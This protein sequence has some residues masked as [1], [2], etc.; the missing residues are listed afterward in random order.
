M[1][2]A[3]AGRLRSSPLAVPKERPDA[4]DF[5][6]VAS[7]F[8]ELKTAIGLSMD[9][10]DGASRVCHLG[11]PFMALMSARCLR[12][13]KEITNFESDFWFDE[14]PG[15]PQSG[16]DAFGTRP[17]RG[18]AGT[19]MAGLARPANPYLL[20][21]ACWQRPFRSSIFACFRSVCEG[22]R[23]I[24]R[25]HDGHTAGDPAKTIQKALD[26]RCEESVTV[27]ARRALKGALGIPAPPAF[28]LVWGFG[29]DGAIAV[30][31]RTGDPK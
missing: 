24:C 18:N 19:V 28:S 22:R 17:V 30:A 31:N 11:R 7:Q 15:A 21:R 13:G 2:G 1:A 10:V 25:E 12:P 27:P 29:G 20:S 5:Q 3:S 23:P 4:R 9:E 26:F 6:H 16:D 8:H 14:A